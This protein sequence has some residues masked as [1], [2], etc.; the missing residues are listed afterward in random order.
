[1]TR[2]SWSI[3]ASASRPADGAPPIVPIPNEVWHTLEGF[4]QGPTNF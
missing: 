2:T 4:S 3:P 1:V